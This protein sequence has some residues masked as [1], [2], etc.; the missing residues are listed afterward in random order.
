MNILRKIIIVFTILVFTSCSMWK[1]VGENLGEGV[2]SSL[3][4]QDS[5]FS[6]ISGSFVKGARDTLVSK[7]T[8]QEI[9]ALVDSIIANLG[10][11]TRIETTS[12]V[13]SLL[14]AYLQLRIKQIGGITQSELISIRNELLGKNTAQ[15]VG[16]LRDQ[17]IGDST[18][19]QLSL[20]RDELLGNN[21]SK[22]L[23]SLIYS[24]MDALMVK[25][26]EIRPILSEDFREE[27]SWVQ[28]NTNTI[29][30]T[31][32]GIT[33]VLLILGGFVYYKSRRFKRISELLTLQINRIPSQDSYD[34]LTSRIQLDAQEKGLEP[35]LRDILSE[36]GIKGE[37]GWNRK[38]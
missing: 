29:L 7:K 22:K 11:K 13:D 32:G 35:A 9:N 6:S 8:E 30:Y 21:S 28:K 33:S 26:E 18:R 23:D 4:G 36:H 38:K 37:D 15:L 5:L 10:S 25:Y 27:G 16:K 14:G 17:L 19:Q 1:D 12:I 2:T 3:E 20:L 34:E 24:A 31:S